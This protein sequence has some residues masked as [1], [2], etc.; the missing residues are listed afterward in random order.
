MQKVADRA[1]P[2]GDTPGADPA[3][4]SPL[5]CVPASGASLLGRHSFVGCDP[6]AKLENGLLMYSWKIKFYF[7]I[8]TL[9]A[10]DLAGSEPSL[11]MAVVL[12]HCAK[13]FRVTAFV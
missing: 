5:H 7:D 11:P 9:L 2:L 3:T 8:F 4:P 6:T 1:S 13:P 12:M 10:A